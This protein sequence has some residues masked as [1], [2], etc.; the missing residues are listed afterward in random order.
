MDSR[1]TI[2]EAP[3]DDLRQA[4]R[5]QGRDPYLPAAKGIWWGK[6]ELYFTCTDGGAIK[7]G[8]IYRLRPGA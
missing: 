6:D 1:S 3:E 7:H 8:Q 5:C 4:R 2:P